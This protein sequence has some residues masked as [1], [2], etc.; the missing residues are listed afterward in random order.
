MTITTI[1][2]RLRKD[3]RFMHSIRVH[4]ISPEEAIKIAGVQNA[5]EYSV[6]EFTHPYKQG[7]RYYSP[8]SG[9]YNATWLTQEGR[10][11]YHGNYCP[12][13]GSYCLYYGNTCISE[14]KWNDDRFKTFGDYSYNEVRKAIQFGLV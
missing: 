1:D 2:Y 14:G 13:D 11:A 12:E 6:T 10:T 5:Y 3:D 4:F 9:T 7:S 8:A